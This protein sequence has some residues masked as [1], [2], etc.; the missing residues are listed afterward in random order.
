[1]TA[2]G[3]L[4]AAW[5]R[6]DLIF[7]EPAVTSRAVMRH[8]ETWFVKL[9]HKDTP[10]CFG[11]GECGLFRSLSADDRADYGDIL[12]R[13]CASVSEGNPLP[14]FDGLPSMKFGFET[15]LLDLAGGGRR[16]LY[17]TPWSR[18]ESAITINGL[19]WMGS[20]REMADR[21]ARKLEAG[22]RCIKIKIGGIDFDR[23]LALLR[24]LRATFSPADVELRLD[25]NG[26]FR[27]DEALKRLEL[28]APLGIH[29]I[30]QPVRQGQHEDMRRI[31]RMSPIPVALDEELIGIEGAGNKKSLIE[32]LRPAYIIL[33]PSL[34][35]GIEGSLEWITAAGEAGA[36]WWLTSALESN[37]GL[38]AIA[39]FA[40]H[41]GVTMPQGLGT[42]AL[43]TNNLPSPLV[44]ERDIVRTDPTL[45]WD[46]SMLRWN[47]PS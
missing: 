41:L 43:Y 30:E 21:M 17:D 26:A 44:Q 5:C 33:K 47:T 36:G 40:A 32:Q 28:L 45:G 1:M 12:A 7:R 34:C 27:P 14:D 22:F 13:V 18:G 15:A 31:C 24:K 29:S 16:I 46:L 8:K 2:P 9:W 42:G 20:E 6:H 19:V 3:D 10:E 38:N 37:I 11:I 25:A 4:R 35:G 23:E 39:Q